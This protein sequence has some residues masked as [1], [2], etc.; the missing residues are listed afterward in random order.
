MN[1][2]N[3][4]SNKL[5][6]FWT[7]SFSYKLQSHLI[8]GN[9]SIKLNLLSGALFNKS[10]FNELGVTGMGRPIILVNYSTESQPNCIIALAISI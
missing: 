7:T 8:F 9:R 5:D 3:I 4:I 10:S 2:Q 6:L 1:K